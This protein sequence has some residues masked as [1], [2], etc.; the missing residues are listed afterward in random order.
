MKLEVGKSY[1]TQNGTRADCVAEIPP[2]RYVVVIR[3]HQAYTTLTGADGKSATSSALDIVG[4]WEEEI[5]TILCRWAALTPDG[6]GHVYKNLSVAESRAKVLG[7][8]AVRWNHPGKTKKQ[9]NWI[10]EFLPKDR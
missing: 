2:D 9:V 5:P 10:D 7:T 3:R 6:V 1:R 8:S 4:P